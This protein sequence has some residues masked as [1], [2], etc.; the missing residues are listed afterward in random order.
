MFV[1]QHEAAIADFD[2]GM[3]NNP[4]GHRQTHPFR[5]TKRRPVPRQRSGGAIYDQAG[6]QGV[7]AR[8]QGNIGMDMA[9]FWSCAHK[10][11]LLKPHAD[12]KNI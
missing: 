5:C 8:W 1:G 4:A 3:T 9:S 10:G 2:L 12:E 7:V 6:R 11:T